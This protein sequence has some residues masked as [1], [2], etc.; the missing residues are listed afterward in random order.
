M[1]AAHGSRPS[2]DG[3]GVG[4][5]VATP[6]RLY[7]DGIAHYLRSS[8]EFGVLGTSTDCES[9]IALAKRLSPDVILLDMALDNSHATART[10]RGSL[11]SALIIA[12]AVPES[13]GHVLGCVE[14]GISAYVPRDA[15]LQELVDT[16]RAAL[17][18]EIRCSPRIVAGLF[19]RI[20]TLSDRTP[21][22]TAAPLTRRE[23]EVLGLIADGLSNKQI[24]RRLCIAV[25]TV[26][27]HVHNILE[28]LGATSR[29]DAVARARSFDRVLAREA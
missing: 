27:N 5:L 14:A 4:V 12:L 24:A 25:P 22:V 28:K 9:T 3:S 8:S 19:R 29:S 1:R 18:G 20:A 10:L 23:N 6:I 16:I 26:K 2:D 13:E 7:Q 17:R 11:P 15:S 21:T